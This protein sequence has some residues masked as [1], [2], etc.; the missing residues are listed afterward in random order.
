MQERRAS[1]RIKIRHK[2]GVM[3]SDE[4]VHYVWTYDISLGG[5]QLLSEYNAD[6]GDML[7]IFLNIL[8]VET[9]EYVRVFARVRVAHT[10][11]DGSEHCFR[12][13][14]EFIDFEGDGR[15]IYNRHLDA[16]LYSRYGQH[17]GVG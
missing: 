16:R 12:I 15:S 7:R 3:L 10:V 1:P 4:S 14:A 11:Y 2:V 6:T 8:D 17:L 9:D 5:L 13:G